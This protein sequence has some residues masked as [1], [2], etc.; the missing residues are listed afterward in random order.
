MTPLR[1]PH[2]IGLPTFVVVG[3]F[4]A[5]LSKVLITARD[6]IPVARFDACAITS[7]VTVKGAMKRKF[8]VGLLAALLPICALQVSA[9]DITFDFAGTIS[10]IPLLD[11][12]D[13]FG[14]TI[15]DG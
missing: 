12:N 8:L 4:D 5:W 9:T 6:G 10:Q 13:P 1:D 3:V 2:L 14:G 11:P 7:P 15:C